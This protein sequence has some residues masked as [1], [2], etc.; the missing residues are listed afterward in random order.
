MNTVLAEEPGK[1]T[2]SD[3]EAQLGIEAPGG[4]DPLGDLLETISEALSLREILPRLSRSRTV[5]CG[6]TISN[7]S[8]GIR[9]AR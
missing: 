5:S 9:Q 8:F 1:A 4:F 7:W 2:Q 6:T 3:H